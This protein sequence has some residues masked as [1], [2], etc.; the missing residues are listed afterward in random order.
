MYDI[1]EIIEDL[2]LFSKVVISIIYNNFL[3][4]IFIFY[5]LTILKIL[6]LPFS[7]QMFD[8]DDI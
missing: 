6:T 7:Y 5:F 2:I 8:E 4:I 3:N 1:L